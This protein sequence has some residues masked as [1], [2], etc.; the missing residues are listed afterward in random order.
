MKLDDFVAETL[1][2]IITGVVKA[3]EFG[4]TQKAN[5]NPVT[6]RLHGSNENRLVC[7][8]TGIPLQVVAFDVAVTVS[9]EKSASDGN[10][11]SIGSIS[12]SPASSSITQNSSMNRIK[13][14]V[15]ILLPTTGTLKDLGY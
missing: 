7:S 12:V 1:K 3:Q 6:G 8:E 14:K 4:N 13:F 11:A 2:Q 10:N 9:E 5:I 15:P